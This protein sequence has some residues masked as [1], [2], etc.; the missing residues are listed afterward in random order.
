[1]NKPEEEQEK[2]YCTNCGTE[3]LGQFCSR[4]G[5]EDKEI[6]LPFRKIVG[7]LLLDFFSIDTRFFRTLIPLLFKPGKLSEEYLNGKRMKY[8]PPLKLFIFSSFILFFSISL[9]NSGNNFLNENETPNENTAIDSAFQNIYDSLSVTH[10]DSILTH[11]QEE[12]P[13]ADSILSHNI[14]NAT[15]LDSVSEEISWWIFQINNLDSI[16]PSDSPLEKK[17]K[18]RINKI[19]QNPE[20]FKEKF[21]SYT[22]QLLF[23]LLPVFALFLKIMY[24][25]QKKFYIQHLV[26]SAHIHAF[27]FVFFVLIHFFKFIEYFWF[28]LPLY[29]F[30]AIKN[31]YKQGWGK[32]TLKFFLITIIYNFV[33]LL[34][35]VLI[36]IFTFV[37][38]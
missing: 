23:L 14:S 30:L 2:K 12:N 18:Q 38:F 1:M 33:V 4:C 20:T 34:F 11:F 3:L 35:A 10:A 26:F 36:L 19:A 17:L 9:Q 32:T 5:Q 37:F 24:I 22:S 8:I 29:I 6:N 27:I 25:R 31:F 16:S 21:L 28:V 15:S 7:Q 13:I